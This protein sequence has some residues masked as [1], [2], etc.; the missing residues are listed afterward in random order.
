MFL[1]CCLTDYDLL[2]SLRNYDLLLSDLEAMKE[3]EMKWMKGYWQ[4]YFDDLCLNSSTHYAY[5]L[6]TTIS[7]ILPNMC[8]HAY[9]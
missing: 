2:F 1:S 3:S 4:R 9:I 5:F 7:F 8:I 6:F